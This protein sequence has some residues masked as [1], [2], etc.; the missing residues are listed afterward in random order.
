MDGTPSGG[1][2]WATLQVSL[3][4][5][6]YKCSNW[7]ITAFTKLKFAHTIIINYSNFYDLIVI[8]IIYSNVDDLI[9]IMLIFS[10]FDDLIVIMII[11]SNFDY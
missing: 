4:S 1:P 7:V 9:L 3:W 8:M 6:V 11:Y 2:I 5:E 10:N